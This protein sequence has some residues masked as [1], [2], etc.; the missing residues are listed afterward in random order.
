MIIEKKS[1]VVFLFYVNLENKHRDFFDFYN[2]K[3]LMIKMP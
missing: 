3:E 1:Q 2:L